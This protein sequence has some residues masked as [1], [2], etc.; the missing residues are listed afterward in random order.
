MAKQPSARPLDEHVVTSPPALPANLPSI[1]SAKLPQAYE[2]AR[3]AL[4]ACERLDECK[5][6]ADKMAALASYAKQADDDKL[7]QHAVRIKARAIKRCGELLEAIRPAKNQ[8]DADDRARGGAP[9]SRAAVARDAGM[10]DD[11]RKQALRV[12]AIPEEQFEALV[13]SDNPPTISQLEEIGTA[14]A[15]VI[16]VPIPP[17][18][19]P[20]IDL[21]GRD[22]DDFRASTTGQ[23]CVRH[24]AD[25]A[26][27]VAPAVV[28]RG[29]FPV[30]VEALERNAKT[31]AQWIGDL[32]DA[33][34]K[35]RR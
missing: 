22:P 7:M 15:T 28:V 31:V 35:E 27:R 1:A 34:A 21:Q 25:F 9:P 18:P 20:L 3:S 14:R 10:S 13:E 33:L 26:S 17:P 8:H 11:Q 23:G 5:D 19:R 6:W 16:D 32:V 12:A 24:L 4:A 2:A 30:E 29:A